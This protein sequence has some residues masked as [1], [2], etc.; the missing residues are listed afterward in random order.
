MP[1]IGETVYF[2]VP[3]RQRGKLDAR[4]R[5]GV[6]LGRSISS[7]QSTRRLTQGLSAGHKYGAT[8]RNVRQPD[9]RSACSSERSA[10]GSAAPAVVSVAIDAPDCGYLRT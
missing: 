9:R 1:E 7:D 2:F 8:L 5:V 10:S 3:K 4:W 6:F